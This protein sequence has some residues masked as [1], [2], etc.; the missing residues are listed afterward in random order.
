MADLSLSRD[1][2]GRSVSREVSRAASRSLSIQDFTQSSLTS[3][4]VTGSIF[5]LQR[6][7]KGVA[8]AQARLV[9]VI[10]DVSQELHQKLSQHDLLLEQLGEKQRSLQETFTQV[11]SEEVAWRQ[12]LDAEYLRLRTSDGNVSTRMN[13]FESKLHQL[14]KIRSTSSN[15]QGSTLQRQME[16][17]RGNLET[18]EARLSGLLSQQL[19][20]QLSEIV[21]QQLQNHVQ[22]Q[23]QQQLQA[24][25]KE[26]QVVEVKRLCEEQV[27]QVEQR[28]FSGQETL[29]QEAMKRE[30]HLSDLQDAA[31]RLAQTAMQRAQA[32]TQAHAQV[33]SAS[34]SLAQRLQLVEKELQSLQRQE[35]E[36]HK[37]R[38]ARLEEDLAGAAP[39]EEVSHSV[40]SAVASPTSKLQ[41]EASGDM[42]HRIDELRVQLYTELSDA[43]NV[44]TQLAGRVSRCESDILELRMQVIDKADAETV[45]TTKWHSP[46]QETLQNG[47]RPPATPDWPASPW[48][49]EVASSMGDGSSRRPA[50]PALPSPPSP[51]PAP[52]SG[53]DSAGPRNSG[54]FLQG[55]PEGP[56]LSS[57]DG[58]KAI[59]PQDSPA[60]QESPGSRRFGVLPPPKV[61]PAE[62]GTL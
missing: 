6:D 3:A 22:P 31:Q 21:Q 48:Q 11:Q 54:A 13:F 17:F 18:L 14:E 5:S 2:R 40:G 15:A 7:V 25:L 8:D 58:D 62:P 42:V 49:V 43:R 41:N 9:R 55:V 60:L 45:K 28:L 51:A 26:V 1:E 33:F 47:S 50:L 30:Q 38:I 23:L 61:T 10:E 44:A 35:K 20:T 12:S 37:R 56:Q 4:S 52:P 36:R 39:L 53:I 57:W 27:K 59:R 46:V 34:S 32:S 19:Q 16:E 24:Q 29:R